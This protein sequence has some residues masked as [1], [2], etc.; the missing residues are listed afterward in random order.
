[1]IYV[2]R[3]GQSDLNKERKMQGRK[4]L[5]LNEH[6]IEQAKALRDRLQNIKFDIVFSSPQDRAVQT[7]EIVTGLK[8]HIDERLDVFDL[9][10]ADRLS[11]NEVKMAGPLP[12]SSVYKGIEDPD[13]FVKRVFSFMNELENQHG[14]RELNILIAG[15]RC[16]TGCIGAY[17]EGIPTD[18]NILSFSSD[19]GD[20]K[21]YVFKKSEIMY[22]G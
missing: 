7:A 19:T 16:T 21:T 3:H 15:H 18:G 6:G 11:V 2:V 4:G 13:E 22:R 14:T 5:A 8:A 20:Y 17:F 12:D 9:G 1:M 10:E